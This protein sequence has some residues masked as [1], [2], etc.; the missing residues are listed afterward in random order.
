MVIKRSISKRNYVL[1]FV[2]TSMIFTIAFLGGMITDRIF[3]DDVEKFN[4]ETRFNLFRA[5]L[6]DKM[7]EDELCSYDF[8]SPLVK[9][10]A[11]ISNEIIHLENRLGK[12]HWKV[13][14]LKKYYTL[15]EMYDW[16]HYKKLK[17]NCGSNYDLI[18]YFYSNQD[19]ETGEPECECDRQGFILGYIQENNLNV[20]VYSFDYN[21]EIEEIKI[22][23]E[24]YGI[25]EVPSLVINGNVLHGFSE[26]EDIEY[27]L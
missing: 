16:L 4:D 3:L 19:D 22:L 10:F 8:E 17:E 13:V 24:K 11:D 25:I 7:M 2:F 12:D 20:R 6:R 9:E 23:K 5:E 15:L 21:L 27:F 26:L 1:A 18:L 14:E